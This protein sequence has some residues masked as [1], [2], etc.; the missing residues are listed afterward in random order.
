MARIVSAGGGPQPSPQQK[1]PRA[2]AW[3]AYKKRRMTAPFF[4]Y[5]GHVQALE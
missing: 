2:G 5:E 1:F 3:P 4:I